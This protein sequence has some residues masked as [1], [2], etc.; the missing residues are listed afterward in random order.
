MGKYTETEKFMRAKMSDSAHDVQHIY[1][2]L[3][4]ALE[5]AKTE[6]ADLEILITACLM[7]DVGRELQ[8]KNP[9]LDHA[10]EGAKI[11][12]D[13]LISQNWSESRAAHVA[14]CIETHRYRADTPPATIEAKILFDADKVD[15]AGAIGIARTLL[16]QGT[17]NELLYT[18]LESGEPDFSPEKSAPPSFIKEYNFKLKNLYDRFFTARGRELA[19]ERKAAAENFYAAFLAE[20][21]GSCAEFEK[22]NTE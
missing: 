7:H 14:A 22:H 4:T 13:F 11:A 9:A 6:C 10:R 21:S 16:Y 8:F 12:Y 5:I 15:V 20:I 17:E 3:N 2:V 19:L 1:R 18:L